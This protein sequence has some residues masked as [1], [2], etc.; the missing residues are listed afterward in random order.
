MKKI[1]KVQLNLINKIILNEDKLNPFLWKFLENIDQFSLK[2]QWGT[3]S[4]NE[5]NSKH[6]IVFEVKKMIKYD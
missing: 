1:L 5:E 2:N 3:K 6:S 4:V